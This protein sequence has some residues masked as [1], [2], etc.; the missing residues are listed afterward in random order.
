[1]V[2]TFTVKGLRHSLHWRT[3]MRVDL[4]AIRRMREASALP[5][6]GQVGPFGQI[7]AST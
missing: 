2:P 1:M 4:P 5:Q 6:C 7:R 3:P